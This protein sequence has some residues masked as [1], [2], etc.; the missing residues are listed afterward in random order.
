MFA[1]LYLSLNFVLL[2]LSNFSTYTHSRLAVISLVVLTIDVMLRKDHCQPTF[3]S[4]PVYIYSYSCSIRTL[5]S[6]L[7]LFSFLPDL[8]ISPTMKVCAQVC[9]AYLKSSPFHYILNI[10]TTISLL[11]LKQTAILYYSFYYSPIQ[12]V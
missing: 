5:S 7:A 9:L 1:I 12:M 8:F 2:V 6:I 4:T 10:L 11:I 3:R